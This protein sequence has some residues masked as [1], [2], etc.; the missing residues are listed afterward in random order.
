MTNLEKLTHA[1]LLPEGIPSEEKQVLESLSHE[2]M[3][4]LL[5]VKKKQDIALQGKAPVTSLKMV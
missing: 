1:G 2:E 3:Q 4:V 5:N